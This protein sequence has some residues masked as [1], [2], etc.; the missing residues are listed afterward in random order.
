MIYRSDCLALY[1]PVG[2]L[3]LFGVSSLTSEAETMNDNGMMTADPYP[4]RLTGIISYES[5]GYL[6][7]YGYYRPTL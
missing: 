1:Y 6:A 2:H 5:I 7:I 3:S 4:A